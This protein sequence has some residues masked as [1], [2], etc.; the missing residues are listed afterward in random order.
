M[1]GEWKRGKEGGMICINE[2][3]ITE[4]KKIFKHIL[5]SLGSNLL[6]GVNILNVS[7]PVTIF[8]K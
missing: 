6:K 7:L 1:K 8:K 4:Q 2:K 3:V 5:S